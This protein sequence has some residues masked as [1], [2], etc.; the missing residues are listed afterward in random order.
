MIYDDLPIKNGDFPVRYVKNNQRLHDF[1]HASSILHWYK[2]V[3]QFV[4]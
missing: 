4:S 2:V 3:P 1:T